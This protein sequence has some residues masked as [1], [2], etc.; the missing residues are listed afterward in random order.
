MYMDI[1]YVVT[2]GIKNPFQQFEKQQLLE[3]YLYALINCYC[4]HTNTNGQSIC[5]VLNI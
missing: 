2:E 1:M 4:T 3:K 5:W